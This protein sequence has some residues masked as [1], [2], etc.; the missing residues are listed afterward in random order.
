[1]GNAIYLVKAFG[2]DAGDVLWWTSGSESSEP[3]NHVTNTDLKDAIPS[4]VK[5]LDKDGD[6]FVDLF[7]VGDLGGQLHRFDI[8]QVSADSTTITHDLV[9]QLGRRGYSEDYDQDRRFFYPP[10]VALM[11]NGSERFVGIAI[12]SGL[13]TA[14]NDTNVDERFYFIKDANPF[15]ATAQDTLRTGDSTLVNLPI[16][17]EEGSPVSGSPSA[18]TEEQ[19]TAARGFSMP[20]LLDAE[21]FLGSPLILN[22][23][24]VFTTYSS[25]E[26]EDA[27]DVA[28]C[29][30]G[31]GSAAL[32]SYTPGQVYSTQRNVR[33]PQTL[34]GNIGVL[35]PSTDVTGDGS[36]TS[37]LRD[38]QGWGGGPS[39]AID[40]PDMDTGN[41]RKTRWIQCRTPECE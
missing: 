40:L 3:G 13:M 23:T 31:S 20:L 38:I 12:G 8:K 30:G 28:Q 18:P 35:F 7:Y 29:S 11:R 32:Y 39:G 9:A 22:G 5:V 26:A 16:V 1:M 21:K 34:A 2:D 14:P 33:L 37:D 10:S 41:I 25:E 15:S 4:T 6:G 27:D 19:I 36:G 17:D 24:V